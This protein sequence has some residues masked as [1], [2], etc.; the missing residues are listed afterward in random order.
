MPAHNS[1]SLAGFCEYA[2]MPQS[3]VSWTESGLHW[4]MQGFGEGEFC[5]KSLMAI[6]SILPPHFLRESQV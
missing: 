1:E 2:A 5:A 3:S 4:H 6:Q